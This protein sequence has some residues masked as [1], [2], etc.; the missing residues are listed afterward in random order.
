MNRKQMS[1]N[2]NNLTPRKL[3]VGLA[4]LSALTV[5]SIYISISTLVRSLLSTDATTTLQGSIIQSPVIIIIALTVITISFLVTMILFFVFFNSKLEDSQVAEKMMRAIVDTSPLA[6]VIFDENYRCIDVNQSTL[7]L[8]R[9]PNKSVYIDK[10]L[11]ICPEYQPCGTLTSEKILTEI[12]R[13]FE[14]G[15]TELEWMHKAW[16]DGELIPVQVTTERVSVGK[17]RVLIAYGRDLRDF[18]RAKEAEHL[19]TQKE[20]EA[21]EMVNILLETAPLFIE[22]W[23]ENLNLYDCNN[24]FL[25]LYNL[26]HKEDFFARYPSLSPEY[27][28]DGMPSKEKLELLL[29]RALQDGYANA[30]WMHQTTDGHEL[31][32]ELIYVPLIWHNQ[33]IIVGYKHDLRQLKK[34]MNEIKLREVAEESNREKSKFLARMSHEIRTPITSV[35]GISE[36]Q[37]QNHDLPPATRESF[38]RINTSANSLLHIINDILDFSKIEAGKMSILN[39]MYETADLIRDISH[40]GQG[41]VIHKNVIFYLH[42]DENL[43]ARLIG[44]SLRISQI[45]NNLLSNAFKYTESGSVDLSFH[46]T[47]SEEQPILSVSVK[48]TGFGMTQKQINALMTGEYMRFHESDDQFISG[49]GLGMPIV[50]NLLKLLGGEIHIESEVGKGTFIIAT[51]PQT[52][53]DSEILGEETVTRLE[54]F[55]GRVLYPELTQEFK[56]DPLPYGNVLVVDDIESNLYVAKEL[57]SLYRLNIETCSSGYDAIEKIG[58]GHVYDIIFMDQMMPN[59]SGTE[60]M[61]ALRDLGYTEPIVLLTADA[62]LGQSDEFKND[63]FDAFIAKPIQIKQLS[64]LLKEFIPER[65]DAQSVITDKTDTHSMGQENVNFL[66][67]R[68]EFYMR[69]KSYFSRDHKNAAAKLSDAIN[70]GDLET[71]HRLAHTLKSSAGMI[72]EIA[73]SRAAGNAEATLSKGNVPD[74]EQLLTIETALNLALE[75][76]DKQQPFKSFYNFYDKSSAKRTFEKLEPLLLAQSLDCLNMLE[77]IRKFPETAILI[78]QIERF[79][80]DDALKSLKLIREFYE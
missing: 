77:E 12:K 25:D 2:S 41:L 76:I 46:Y 8:H 11:D 54:L 44:D 69:L 52:T 15:H 20:Q 75:R 31:P 29:Q 24:R 14:E 67:N 30:E 28:P 73:L 80:F 33:T 13:G 34:I 3:I 23:D 63:D 64:A 62:F 37:L 51:I 70:S 42:V 39:Y 43:P 9:L 36:I 47:T 57:L 45:V 1:L 38:A 7:K 66:Q 18:Y 60:T 71:A 17:R 53:A 35:L 65:E 68:D 10:F 61:H 49:T 72:D 26:S 32:V 78:R 50:Y 59:L 21:T 16:D 22:A 74:S 79:D 40:I 4:I 56:P 5:I 19:A 55:E 6:C 58:Q 48:D 27:Q